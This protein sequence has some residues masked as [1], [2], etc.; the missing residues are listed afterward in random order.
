MKIISIIFL[1]I[2]I[3]WCQN[4]CEDLKKHLINTPMKPEY[5]YALTNLSI[6]CVE[7]IRDIE[8]RYLKISNIKNPKLLEKTSFMDALND[9]LILIN[10]N[11]SKMLIKYDT[12]IDLKRNI[13]KSRLDNGRM[14]FV[15]HKP[16]R[17]YNVYNFWSNDRVKLKK[18][19]GEMIKNLIRSAKSIDLNQSFE[20]IKNDLLA[21]IY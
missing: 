11:M 8:N 7:Y 17:N 3:L 19:S 5:K 13:L 18:L 9:T 12:M 6:E 16:K 15:Y 1:F 20:N 14:S 21:I 2:N 4:P 10:Q